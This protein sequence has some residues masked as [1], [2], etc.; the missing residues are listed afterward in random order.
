MAHTSTVVGDAVAAIVTAMR[1]RAGYRSPWV[2]GAPGDVIVYHSAEVG[3]QAL[4]AAEAALLLVVGDTGDPDTPREAG[5]STQRPA[6]LGTRRARQEDATV[7]VRAIAQTG[8][9]GEG[10]VAAQWSAALDILDDLD[11]ELRGPTGVGPSLGLVPTFQSVVAQLAQVTAVRPYVAMGTVV[12]AW[13][14]VE[15][16]ARL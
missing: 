10:V 6:T 11:D 2:A 15:V 5:E 13:A 16:S 3:L 14:D 1:A 8:D 12:E 9:V 7:R 4:G